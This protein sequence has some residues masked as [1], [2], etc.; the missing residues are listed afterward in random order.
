M[1]Q[2]LLLLIAVTVFT[3]CKDSDEAGGN[4]RLF[5]PD[6]LR[7]TQNFNGLTV[8]WDRSPGSAA[9]EVELSANA[10]FD[11][12][13]T[14]E[15]VPGDSLIARFKDLR[16]ETFYYIRMRGLSDR[17][18]LHSKYV[19][20]EGTTGKMSS[21]FRQPSYEEMSYTYATLRW[22]AEYPGEDGN[23]LPVVADTLVLLSA[24]ANPIEI[25][26]TAADLAAHS[27]LLNGLYQGVAYTVNMMN[28]GKIVSKVVFTTP[29]KPDGAIEVNSTDNL[30]S[31]IES[32]PDGATVILEGGQ[33]YDCSNTV[34]YLTKNITITG[35]PGNTTPV[36]YIK[37]FTLGG[38][39]TA[40][41]ANIHSISLSHLE[42]SGMLLEGGEEA[43]IATVFP[44]DLTF[45]IEMVTGTAKTIS[46]DKLSLADCTVR[47]YKASVVGVPAWNFPAGSSL[48]FGEISVEN[49][50]VFDIGRAHPGDL[51][52][53]IHLN[54]NPSATDLN[55]YCA[56]YTL[57]SSTFYHIENGLIEARKGAY[58]ATGIAPAVE[59]SG[60]TFDKFAVRYPGA[61]YDTRESSRYFF[62]FAG[63]AVTV[64]VRNSI[65]G[66][67]KTGAGSRLPVDPFDSGSSALIFTNTYRAD[68]CG[69]NA[70]KFAGA[71][72]A[73]SV[74]SIFPGREE[75]N[76]AI[77][78]DVLISGAGDPRWTAE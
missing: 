26:L 29:V 5:M 73:G 13:E 16:E 12:I 23:L 17:L 63:W 65:F 72:V 69:F 30:K 27:I 41:N 44:N 47:N 1:K 25:S 51:T 32:A 71:A 68:E 35:A 50:L 34:I 62:N 11:P 42:L 67:M 18:E 52:S 46:I 57:R 10:A 15:T 56:K 6:N 21:F 70:S 24:G 8:R 59:I 2:I 77:S 55:A 3:A 76:F 31:V 37:Q 58:T 20:G 49:A 19:Y 64:Q 36:L 60:C 48:F 33:V 38:A 14:A 61:K 54:R 66:Q 28:E 7:T 43:D 74:E 9:Y 53:F 75:F 40:G 78:P 45:G 39:A 4:A 22:D